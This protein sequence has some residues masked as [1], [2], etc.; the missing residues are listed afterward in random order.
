MSLYVFP[1]TT[2]HITKAQT[3]GTVRQIYI[4]SLLWY[5]KTN[6]TLYC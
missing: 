4:N 6:Q 5:Q 3:V 2:N 1:H